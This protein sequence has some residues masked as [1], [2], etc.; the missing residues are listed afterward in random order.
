MK[1]DIFKKPKHMTNIGGQALIEGLMMIGPRN[2]AIAIRKPDGEIIVEK[3]P[4]PKKS[5]F[6]KLPI[7]RGF[8]GIFK[9]M[10]LGIKALMYS[11]EFVDL[12]DDS[13]ED[14]KPSKFENFLDRVFGD[15]IEEILIYISVVI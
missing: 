6:S 8:V 4:L 9:Q 15:K 5:K 11:A 1:Q 7:V 12:E 2:A 3:R 14:K 10:V 13:E